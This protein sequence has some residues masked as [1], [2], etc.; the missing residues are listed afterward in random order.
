[1]ENDRKRGVAGQEGVRWSEMATEL[2]CR[3]MYRFGEENGKTQADIVTTAS[4]QFN[5]HKYYVGIP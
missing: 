3:K 5:V 4:C 2:V 1:M